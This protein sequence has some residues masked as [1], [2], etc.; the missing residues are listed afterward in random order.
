MGRHVTVFHLSLLAAIA[1]LLCWPVLWHGAPDLSHDGVFHVVLDKAFAEQFWSGEWYPRWLAD[2]N[3]GLGAA[4]FFFYPPLPSYVSSMFAPTLAGHD[5]WGWRAVGLSCALAMVLSA[6]TAYFWLRSMTGPAAAL[7]GATVYL[8]SPYH[9]AVDLYTRGAVSE[10]WA[11]VWMPA[12]M[13]CVVRL[14]GGSRWAF[15]GLALSYSLLTFSHLITTVCFSPV[16]LA[17]GFWLSDR[18]R[19]MRNALATGAAMA[20]GFGLAGVYV[21]PAV[22][23]QHKTHIER[24]FGG[25]FDYR[26]WWIPQIPP[27]PLHYKTRLLFV[28]VSILLFAAVLLWVHL[29]SAPPLRFRRPAWF[30]FAMLL[31]AFWLTTQLSSVVWTALPFLKG[32]QF[33]WRFLTVMTVA[34]AALAALAF[35]AL[36]K[37]R[38]RAVACLLGLIGILWIAADGWAAAWAFSAWRHIPEERAQSSREEMRLRRASF[39]F[40]PAASPFDMAFDLPKLQTFLREHPPKSLILRNATT[41]ERTGSATVADWRPREVVLQISAPEEARL[42]ISHFYYSGWGGRIKGRD[43]QALAVAPASHGLVQVDV[44]AGN[45]ELVLDLG[46]EEP[47]RAGVAVS[48]CSAAVILGIGLWA[49]LSR[50]KESLTRPQKGTQCQ[51]L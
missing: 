14:I 5:P 12:V 11:F 9:T 10:F 13:L 1:L 47:E 46:R 30:Y 2:T 32:L 27:S 7:F 19:R 24:A 41:G 20:L 42:T 3:G 28:A 29:R 4:P 15:P 25:W 39:A 50:G 36:R 38:P 31:G 22:L 44:P 26:N 48:L 45:Y 51:A 35:P 43:K 21:I 17:A 49:G 16:V 34:A 33:P 37:N 40:W 23:D 8:I 18:G 6:I